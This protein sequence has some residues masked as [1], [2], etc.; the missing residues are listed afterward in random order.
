MYLFKKMAICILAKNV[1]LITRLDNYFCVSENIV[2]LVF[3]TKACQ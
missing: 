3:H 2:S 1:F